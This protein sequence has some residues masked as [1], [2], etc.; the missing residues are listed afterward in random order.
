METIATRRNVDGVSTLAR[1]W[2]LSLEAENRSPKT[3]ETYLEA[4]T[5]LER[6]LERAGMPTAVASIRREHVESF[7]ADLL[8]RLKPNTAANRYRA[9]SCFFAFMVDEG[10]IDH[11][12]MA[13]MRPPH[14]PEVPVPVLTDSS[15]TALLKTCNTKDFADVR[16]TAILRVFIDFGIRLSEL[17]HLKLDDIDLE[18][19]TVHVLGKGR[20]PRPVPF[21]PRTAKAIVSYLRARARHVDG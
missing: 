11:S 18:T 20:R 21:G 5:Q 15:L 12:P 3:I 6:F 4:T 8:S 19:K 1:F 10:E 7:I 2:S 16:D 17:T 14:V 13:H 9:L